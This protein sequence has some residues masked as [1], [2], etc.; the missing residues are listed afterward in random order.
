VWV[1]LGLPRGASPLVLKA[2]SG[3]FAASCGS[4]LGFSRPIYRRG[5]GTFLRHTTLDSLLSLFNFQG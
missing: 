2:I 1:H 3:C 4:D 5:G